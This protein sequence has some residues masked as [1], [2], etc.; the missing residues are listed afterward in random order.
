MGL[1]NK[2][3]EKPIG[4]ISAFDLKQTKYK[5]IYFIMF[6]IMTVL[7]LAVIVPTIWIFLT[8]FKGS[9]EIYEIPAKFFP[10]ELDFSRV[11]E[12]WKE[13]DISGNIIS[14]FLLAFGEVAGML[15]VC[16][17]GGYVMSKLKPK[18]IK[19]I[20]V[21]IVLTMMMPSTV[22]IVPL[23]MSFVDFPIGHFSMLNTYWPLI[24]LAA[25]N[26]F[27]LVLF[28]NFFDSVSM[29]IVEAAWIDGCGNI[30]VFFKIMLPLST[31]VI[32]YTAIRSF[33]N[34]WSDFLMPMLVLSDQKLQPVPTVI[35][36]MKNTA[37]VKINNYM[38]SLCIACIPPIIIFAFF[39]KKI[40]G[41]INVGGVKG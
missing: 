27:N 30:R 39:Q 12:A 40:M 10:R 3:K 1:K 36:N 34:V 2:I 5:V 6:A 19:A 31:P 37:I 25:A 29:S 14:T 4:V 15:L 9:Q 18:G 16:G 11:S 28:K 23:Y 26:A 22:R 38:M 21:L 17:F 13:I 8:G 32:I 24:M 20:F 35:F 33:N 7:V 41:G